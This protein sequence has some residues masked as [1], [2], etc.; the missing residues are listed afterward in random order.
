[1]RHFYTLPLALGL[2]MFA[3]SARAQGP[4]NLVSL[5]VTLPQYNQIYVAELDLENVKSSGVLFSATLQSLTSTDLQVKLQMTVN[6][7]LANGNSYQDIADATTRPF[8]LAAHQVKVITNVDMSGNNPLIG[9]ESSHYNSDQ[10]DQLK[11][12]ALATGKAPAGNYQFDI[13]CLKAET[14]QILSEDSKTIT[15]TNPSRVELQL[16]LNQENVTTFIPHFLWLSN[17]D[18]VILAVYEKLP[19]QQSPEDVVSGVPSLRVTVPNSSSPSPGSFI[20]PPSGLG[21]R[22][23]QNGRTYYWYVEIPTSATRGHGIRSDIWSF[24][25]GGTDSTT[26]TSRGGSTG[27]AVTEALKNF[28][29]DTDYGGL[30]QQIEALT[31]QATYDGRS[32]TTQELIQLLNSM[33]KSKITSVTIQ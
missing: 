15:V 10:V 27:N 29:L 16:P 20:Y 6:V 12:V 7:V 9:I 17:V 8:V 19:S 5:T 26:F 21:V 3:F 30:A 14:G 1:M 11:S 13:K 32:L 2:F 31:G 4:Q 28:L 33:D 18:T 22:P 24:T 23:L 25:V